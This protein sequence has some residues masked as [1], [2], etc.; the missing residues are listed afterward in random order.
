M[1]LNAYT[2]Y[3]VERKIIQDLPIPKYIDL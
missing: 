1:E 2:Q 3:L